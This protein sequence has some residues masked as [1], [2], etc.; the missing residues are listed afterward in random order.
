MT[1]LLGHPGGDHRGRVAA[2]HQPAVLVGHQRDQRRDDHRQVRRGDA[3]QLVAEALAA[4]G[5]HHHEAVAAVERRLHRL[6]LPGAELAE[7][8]VPQQRVRIARP[9][10]RALS[11]APRPRSGRAP[12]AR[13]ARRGHPRRTP[14][15]PGH[16][17]ACVRRRPRRRARDRRASATGPAALPA[18]RRPAGRDRSRCVRPAPAP[19]PGS[20]PDDIGSAYGPGR[21]CMAIAEQLRGRVHVLV[22]IDTQTV[23]YRPAVHEA[24]TRLGAVEPALGLPD[25]ADPVARRHVVPQVELEVFPQSRP[26]AGRTGP[27][28]LSPLRPRHAAGRPARAT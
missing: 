22:E 4:A 7:A 13:A 16:R 18:R 3:G 23:A 24:E 19:W 17:P 5:G 27:L 21:T 11:A 1:A 26:G 20:R 6:A 25:H 12:S 9:L 8:E 15:A 28:P 10:V 14:A 2:E